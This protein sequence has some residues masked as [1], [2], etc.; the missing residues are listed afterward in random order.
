MLG[1][2]IFDEQQHRTKRVKSRG[3]L[4]YLGCWLA[5]WLG[6]S[7][8]VSGTEWLVGWK[9]MIDVVVKRK[10]CVCELYWRWLGSV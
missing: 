5:G 1:D 8:A 4:A 10:A 2:V 7:I 6:A 3:L 9:G